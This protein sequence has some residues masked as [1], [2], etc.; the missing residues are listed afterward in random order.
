[1]AVWPGGLPQVVFQGQYQES[2][3]K[4]SINTQ[5]DVGPAKVRPRFTAGVRR[6]Q[7]SLPLKASEV[8][9]LDV[10]YVTTLK[11]GSQPFDWKHPRTGADVTMRF[12]PGT[13]PIYTD[14]GDIFIARL[15]LEILP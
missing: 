14:R 1:M 6:V 9:T 15:E 8:E 13:E 12:K 5:P 10:F 7:F 2:P 11:Y 4:N 3:P